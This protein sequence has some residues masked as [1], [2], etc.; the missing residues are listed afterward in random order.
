M[1]QC[2]CLSECKLHS[3]RLAT[4]VQIILN[5]SALGGNVSTKLLCIHCLWMDP[6]LEVLYKA[7][8]HQSTAKET[9]K[10]QSQRTNNRIIVSLKPSSLNITVDKE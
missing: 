9:M 6:T 2:V 7:S 5:A 1:R 10:K 4:T 8:S 3:L